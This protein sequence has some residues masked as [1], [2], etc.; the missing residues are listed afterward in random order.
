MNYLREKTA[1]VIMALRF[2]K[3]GLTYLGGPLVHF[4]Q[5]TDYTYSV[6]FS[7]NVSTYF[8]YFHF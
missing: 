7:F 5:K 8:M 4:T 1:L 6:S 2:P 3:S